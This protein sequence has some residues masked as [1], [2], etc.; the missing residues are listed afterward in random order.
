MMKKLKAIDEVANGNS[1][2]FISFSNMLIGFSIYSLIVF[3]ISI[4]FTILKSEIS[5]QLSIRILFQLI[6]FI[7]Y[8]I[9]IF[10]FIRLRKFSRYNEN[11][12]FAY[13]FLGIVLII[14]PALTSIASSTYN[15]MKKDAISL[16]QSNQISLLISGFIFVI[17]CTGTYVIGFLFQE[18]SLKIISIISLAIYLI[19]IFSTPYKIIIMD[20]NL[21][22]INIYSSI[23][24][25]MVIFSIGMY[26]RKLSKAV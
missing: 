8:I 12:K 9:I 2:G 10:L 14:L 24:A 22:G 7:F 5:Q 6:T 15:I 25:P 16:I 20:S 11:T 3:I 4:F 1:Q 26:F 18:K 13:G 19:L 21:D 23:S 17:L